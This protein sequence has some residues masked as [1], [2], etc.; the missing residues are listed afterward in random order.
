ML[1]VGSHSDW[2]LPSRNNTAPYSMRPV[3]VSRNINGGESL[4]YIAS[5]KIVKS[6]SVELGSRAVGFGLLK[7]EQ[8]DKV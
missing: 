2:L 5:V 3:R 6:G 8:Q 4:P 7:S 1:A